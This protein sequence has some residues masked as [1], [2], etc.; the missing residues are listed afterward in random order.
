MKDNV[1]MFVV[2]MTYDLESG[3]ELKV[4]VLKEEGEAQ[5]QAW[6]PERN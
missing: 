6:N 3:K 2:E 1:N 5:K 4:Q